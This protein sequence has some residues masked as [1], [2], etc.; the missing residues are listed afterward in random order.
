MNARLAIEEL[1]QRDRA[2]WDRH[3]QTFRSADRAA[4]KATYGAASGNQ[5]VRVVMDGDFQIRALGIHPD[6]YEHLD[7]HDL[8]DSVISA[9]NNARMSVQYGQTE[10][11]LNPDFYLDQERKS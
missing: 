8:A 9:Y 3:H 1:I 10:R 7:E 2:A 4:V 11:A 5:I 6:A